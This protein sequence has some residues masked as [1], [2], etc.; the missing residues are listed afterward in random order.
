MQ[1]QNQNILNL[2]EISLGPKIQAYFQDPLVTEVYMNDDGSVWIDTLDKGSLV[3][4]VILEEEVV[5]SVIALIANSVNQ[6]VT[7]QNPVIS[8]EMPDSG[9]RFEGNIGGISSRSVFNIRK[10]SILELTLQDYVNSDIM[11]E[12]QKQAIEEAVKKHQNILVVGGT[13]SG[14]TTLCN[15]ILSEIAKYQERT[16]I[17]Q[18]TNELKCS[19]PDRL[20]LRSNQYVSMRQLLTSALRRSPRRIVIG[21]VRDGAALNVIKAWNTGH[22][23]GLCTLHADSAEL[24]LFQLESYITEVSQN[25]Q[26]EMIA[27]TVNVLIDIQKEGIIRKLQGI[28]LVEGLDDKNNYILKKI[29]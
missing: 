17:I 15:A 24:G 1:T 12:S 16:I 18:D 13:N 4:D 8:A 2:L 11:T 23:G 25:K 27:R 3:T 22:P 29:A 20:F 14:K 10:H 19:C 9:F 28:F 26:R 6:E 21:E 7:Y 5:Y